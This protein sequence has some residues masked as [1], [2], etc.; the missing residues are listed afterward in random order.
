MSPQRYE[1]GSDFYA[2]DSVFITPGAYYAA[3][4]CELNAVN[5][6]LVSGWT[7]N[8]GEGYA[9]GNSWYPN[10]RYILAEREWFLRNHPRVIKFETVEH[11]AP[12]SFSE[13]DEGLAGNVVLLRPP[14]PEPELAELAELR[15]HLVRLVSEAVPEDFRE[16]VVTES[17]SSQGIGPREQRLNQEIRNAELARAGLPVDSL[18]ELTAQLME[19][20]ARVVAR[21]Q[22][23]SVAAGSFTD[24]VEVLEQYRAASVRVFDLRRERAREDLSRQRDKVVEILLAILPAEQAGELAVELLEGADRSKPEAQPDPDPVYARLREVGVPQSAIDELSGAVAY[25]LGLAHIIA[26]ADA[27]AREQLSRAEENPEQSLGVGQATDYPVSSALDASAAHAIGIESGETAKDPLAEQVIGALPHDGQSD[28]PQNKGGQQQ[29]EESASNTAGV[30]SPNETEEPRGA[31]PTSA[32]QP[33]PDRPDDYIGS[34]PGESTPQSGGPSRGESA[35]FSPDLSGTQMR[36]TLAGLLGGDP[37]SAAGLV[38][39]AALLVDYA[40][41]VAAG[42]NVRLSWATRDGTGR[43]VFGSAEGLRVPEPRGVLADNWGGACFGEFAWAEADA[44]WSVRLSG[45]RKLFRRASELLPAHFTAL[46]ADFGTH[47]VNSVITDAVELAT[48]RRGGLRRGGSLSVRVSGEHLRVRVLASVLPEEMLRDQDVL[49]DHTI[50]RHGAG[51]PQG[52]IGSRPGDGD[53]ARPG[54]FIGSRPPEPGESWHRPV[55]EETPGTT[56]WSRLVQSGPP[57]SSAADALRHEVP[58][59]TAADAAFAPQLRHAMGDPDGSGVKDRGS[60]SSSPPPAP[61]DKRE[62]AGQP[63]TPGSRE[64]SSTG[65]STSDTGFASSAVGAE[66]LA[67]GRTDGPTDGRCGWRLGTLL[68]AGGSCRTIRVNRSITAASICTTSLNS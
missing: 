29:E 64:P 49:F 41:A 3:L 12:A 2:I 51:G 18:G 46:A 33:D 1:I 53:K 27:Q 25:Y 57:S 48:R 68:A 17:R 58:E 20:T 13:N 28:A 47:Q 24:I 15:R 67:G 32:A 22:D 9:S 14:A 39:A 62:N 56:P 42:D 37:S 5:R 8:N 65:G 30:D 44:L 59:L 38:R 50:A 26:L 35:V 43:E 60:D 21:L 4:L 6:V 16:Q 31:S 61:R 36:A 45:D 63:A 40:L 34:R 10:T 54:G 11:K 52:F 55:S 7:I 23:A 66:F 19:D